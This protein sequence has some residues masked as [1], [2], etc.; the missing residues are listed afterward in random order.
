MKVESWTLKVI[1]GWG[2]AAVWMA[3]IFCLSGQPKLPPLPGLAGIDKIQ[4]L[5]AYMVLG[6]LLYRATAG[7]PLMRM[8]QYAQSFLI[9]ALYGASDEYHQSFIPGRQMSGKDWLADIAGL[10]IALL[11]IAMISKYRANGG[12]RIDRGRKGI[13]GR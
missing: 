8:R 2:P 9:G 7:I 5:A 13:R 1:S 12:K 6:L 10:A 11:A 4:H 3:L